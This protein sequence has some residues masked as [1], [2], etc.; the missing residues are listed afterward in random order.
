MGHLEM[1]HEEGVTLECKKTTKK[2]ILRYY[3]TQMT[4]SSNE[5]N[6]EDMEL[7]ILCQTN[8]SINQRINKWLF[9][10]KRR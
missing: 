8:E 5:A 3:S 9:Y 10:N 7:A 2:I 4:I 6:D 1:L